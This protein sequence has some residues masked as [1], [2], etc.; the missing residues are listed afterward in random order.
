MLL[1]ARRLVTAEAIVV[2]ASRAV[3][4]VIVLV[5]GV[6]REKV[7]YTVGCFTNVEG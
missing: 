3:V 7:R 6:S 2:R 5:D 1:L 4:A